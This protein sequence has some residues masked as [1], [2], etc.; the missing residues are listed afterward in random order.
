MRI[1]RDAKSIVPYLK[2]YFNGER[3]GYVQACDTEEGWIDVYKVENAQVA[4]S[5]EN[6]AILERKYGKVELKLEEFASASGGA[7]ECPYAEQVVDPKDVQRIVID[8]ESFPPFPKNACNHP[9]RLQE[10]CVIYYGTFEG[11][12]WD[13]IM[14]LRENT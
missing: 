4:L 6:E 3:H 2:V 1:T 14:A 10:D 9:N 7:Q 5:S 13:R 12:N 8:G 11:C